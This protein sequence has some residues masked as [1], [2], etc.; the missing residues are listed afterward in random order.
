MES[1]NAFADP[2]YKSM[3]WSLTCKPSSIEGA[4]NVFIFIIVLYRVSFYLDM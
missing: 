1:V 4:G 3:H 2:L